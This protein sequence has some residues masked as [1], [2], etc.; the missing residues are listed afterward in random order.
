[1]GTCCQFLREVD[2]CTEGH[3][4]ETGRWREREISRQHRPDTDW[5]D[6]VIDK[7]RPYRHDK[8]K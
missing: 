1:M 3:E 5:A 6:R 8:Q 2:V 7:L 4:R